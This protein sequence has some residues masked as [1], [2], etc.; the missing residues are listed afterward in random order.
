MND[1]MKPA[2]MGGLALGVLTILSSVIP[3]A[4]CCSCLWAI[5]GGTLAAYLYIKKSPAPVQ[6]GDGAALGA[7][8]GAIGGLLYLIIG[9]PLAYALTSAQMEALTEQVRQQTGVTLPLSGLALFFVIGI[10]RVFICIVLAIIGGLIGV[11]IFEKRRGPS[12]GPPPPPPPPQPPPS[13]G[14]EPTQPGAG[15]STFGSGS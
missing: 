10:V 9:T 7:L 11:A 3:A 15:Y 13:Y 8:A 12:A 6:I 4:G 2:L 5:G 14:G 1:K